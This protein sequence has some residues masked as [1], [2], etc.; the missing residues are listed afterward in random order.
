MQHLT[1]PSVEAAL[2]RGKLFDRQLISFFCNYVEKAAA[3]ERLQTSIR[4]IFDIVMNRISPSYGF[5]INPGHRPGYTHSFNRLGESFLNLLIAASKC[6]LSVSG[7]SVVMATS[8]PSMQQK[9]G[10][11]GV[12]LDELNNLFTNRPADESRKRLFAYFVTITL[13]NFLLHD[14]GW[15]PSIPSDLS[16]PE[17][18]CTMRPCTVCNELN[19]F[20]KHPTQRSFLSS[21]WSV[22]NRDHA[23]SVIRRIPAEHLKFRYDKTPVKGS[24]AHQLQVEKID[25]FYKIAIREW[26]AKL[27]K[28]R[29]VRDDVLKNEGGSAE[30]VFGL[31]A[32]LVT[33]ENIAGI[34]SRLN[35]I[36]ETCLPRGAEQVFMLYG[37]EGATP[38]NKKE[39]KRLTDLFKQYGGKLWGT[40]G[41]FFS[42]QELNKAIIIAPVDSDVEKA[43]KEMQ[44]VRTIVTISKLDAFL[45]ECYGKALLKA[46][47]YDAPVSSS[48]ATQTSN[49]ASKKRKASHGEDEN[50]EP[51]SNISNQN[52]RTRPS[53]KRVTRSSGAIEDTAE[54]INLCD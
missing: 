44:S 14:V 52:E 51:L 45:R 48:P 38:V 17:M 39:I 41:G 7:K 54:V 27:G 5:A 15:E 32:D 46:W 9:D 25:E 50:R 16:R 49:S 18:R 10:L 21:K 36:R 33:S 4:N 40:D 22:A 43:E 37:G 30:Q 29:R 26:K 8:M 19:A 12:C 31:F 53:K 6:D 23:I 20:F 42:G 3:V 13:C 2:Q 34:E 28:F 24:S 1:I 47:G 11:A 35:T